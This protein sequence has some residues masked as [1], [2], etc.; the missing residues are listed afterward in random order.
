[1][2]TPTR[3]A[4]ITGGNRGLGRNTAEHLARKGADVILTYR[5][6]RDEAD[7]VVAAIA[8]LGRKA[9]ALP[10]DTT[11]LAGFPGFAAALSAALAETWGRDRFDFLVNNAGTTVRK[12]FAETTEA[13]FDQLVAINLK[14]VFFLTQ[15]L[16]P[17]LADGGRIVLL[18]SGLAR[19]AYPG[20]SAYGATKGAV[21][22]L[23]RYLAKELA[24]RG[25]TV[26]T[27]APGAIATDFGGGVV[28]DNP[29]VNAWIAG[30]TALGRVGL[31]DDIGAAI[32]D[33]LTGQFGWMTAQR[34]ELSG[35]QEL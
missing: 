4:L 17:S 35:G 2:T 5:S 16:L 31:P 30:R 33:L 9:V 15:A 20:Y 13:D 25:I 27:V 26:N 23:G 24:P 10:L 14:G 1:M 6:H 19:F 28:R 18:S 7:A 8:A 34:I 32:A 22:A 21:E 3:I 29:E 12:P 11:D